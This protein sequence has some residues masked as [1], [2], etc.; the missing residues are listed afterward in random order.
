MGDHVVGREG[1]ISEGE[2][3]IAEI[4]GKEIAVFNVDGEYKAYLNWCMHQCGPCAEG[5]VTGTKEASFDAETLE[6]EVEWVQ[7]DEILC[8]P[9]HGWEYDLNSGECLTKEE[10]FL[11]EFPV[12]VNDGEI[13]VS[14]S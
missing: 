4:E 13:V 14:T 6:Y 8:C 5:H 3:V 7:D 11:P 9:W 1:M 10:A 12:D 2:R